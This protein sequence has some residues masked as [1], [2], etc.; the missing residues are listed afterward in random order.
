MR[1][2]NIKVIQRQSHPAYKASLCFNTFN[3][4]G[5][6]FYYTHHVRVLNP[7]HTHSHSHTLPL[8]HLQCVCHLD[9]DQN[10]NISRLNC[11]PKIIYLEK[12]NR[13]TRNDTIRKPAL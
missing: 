9:G 12:V 6:V 11:P 4:Y 1:E 2:V 3:L 8:T 7:G 5:H 13:H 10:K